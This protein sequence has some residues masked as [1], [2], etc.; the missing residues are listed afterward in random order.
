MVKLNECFS[1]FVKW[2]GSPSLDIERT[3]GGWSP[4]VEGKNHNQ[5]QTV[6]AYTLYQVYVI[7]F[8]PEICADERQ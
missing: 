1:Q 3:N 2:F 8:T 5:T 7:C 6:G 4:C